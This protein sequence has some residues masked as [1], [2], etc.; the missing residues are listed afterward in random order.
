M[1]HHVGKHAASL[2]V[3]LPEPRLVRSRMFLGG[4]REIGASTSGY[5]SPPDDVLAAHHRGREKLVL[6]ITVKQA[7]ILDEPA[8]F[9]CFG[10]RA[11]EWLFAS[12]GAQ[13]SAGLGHAVDLAHDVEM[14]VVRRQNPKRIDLAGY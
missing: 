14:A 3:A 9:P 10:K 12:N 11:G 2:F 7:C 13:G 6:Q 8:H 5:R 1:A 4:T